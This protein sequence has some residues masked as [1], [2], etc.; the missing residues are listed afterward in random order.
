[1]ASKETEEEEDKEEQKNKAASPEKKEAEEEMLG[2]NV[3][4]G[5][6][7]AYTLEVYATS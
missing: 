6:Q 2:L 1:M 4:R 7:S 5:V 3:D